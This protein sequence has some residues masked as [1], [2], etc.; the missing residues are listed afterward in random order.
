MPVDRWVYVAFLSI[1]GGEWRSSW[2][3][4]RAS[5]NTFTIPPS[6]SGPPPFRRAQGLRH[7]HG[8]T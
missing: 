6:K 2:G 3:C 1:S 7:G 8:L 5:P 4:T